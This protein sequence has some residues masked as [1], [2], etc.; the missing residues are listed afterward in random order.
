MCIASEEGVFLGGAIFFFAPL[1]RSLLERIF[2]G[3][4]QSTGTRYTGV[5]GWL[6]VADDLVLEAKQNAKG[7]RENRF[8]R[9]P[10]AA[11]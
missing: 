2:T 5:A 7:D 10:D 11:Q 4:Q 8:Q 1:P 6:R 9:T 3:R